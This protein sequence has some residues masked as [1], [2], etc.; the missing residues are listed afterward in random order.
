METVCRRIGGILPR[1]S[2][3]CTGTTSKSRRDSKIPFQSH[4]ISERN[5]DVAKLRKFVDKT[6]LKMRK[7]I[8]ISRRRGG[9][10]VE[11]CRCGESAIAAILAAHLVNKPE[12][13]RL[14]VR[15]HS[16]YELCKNL[17][18]LNLGQFSRQHL[19]SQLER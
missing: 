10:D 9:A 17:T 19:P 16:C 6:F 8:H 15:M 2:A 3:P 5:V 14:E 12:E 7:D 4:E 13:L 18:G 1:C 11:D